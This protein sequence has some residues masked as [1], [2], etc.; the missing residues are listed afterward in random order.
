M[1]EQARWRSIGIVE[2]IGAP[3][4]VERSCSKGKPKWYKSRSLSIV[5]LGLS[6]LNAIGSEA[7]KQKT[8]KAQYPIFEFLLAKW[9][10]AAEEGKVPVTNDGLRAQSRVIQKKLI[11]IGWEEEYTD[12]G[13]S[14]GWL[15]RF[16]DPHMIGRL[17]RH[18]EAG[19]VNLAVVESAKEEIQERLRPC[20]LRYFYSIIVTFMA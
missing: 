20:S 9:V 7:W 1:S 10:D 4:G 3:E 16:K 11:E 18:E 12:F 5:E 14:G 17:K 15:R 19:S 6:E 13:F 2:P 8:R